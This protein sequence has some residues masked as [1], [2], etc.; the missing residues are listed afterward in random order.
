MRASHL[1]VKHASS[2]RP[3][4][5]KDPEGAEILK[6]QPKDAEAILLG[7]RAQ[8]EALQGAE[9]AEAFAKLAQE[10]S[11]CG[12]ARNGGD[13]GEFGPGQMMKPFEDATLALKIGEMSGVVATDSGLHIIFRTG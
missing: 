5:W 2:R 6:R 8:L 10:H 4:S 9:L 11:D 13:L 12:S 3:A 1:L 7:Y